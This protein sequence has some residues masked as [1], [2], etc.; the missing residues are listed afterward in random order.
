MRAARCVDA[1]E[2][3]SRYFFFETRPTALRWACSTSSS[4]CRSTYSRRPTLER[5][6]IGHVD[7]IDHVDRVPWADLCAVLAA[8]ASIEIDVAKSLE[9]CVL[10]AGDLVDAVDRADLKAGLA[11]GATIG[12]NHRQN[13]GDDFSRLSGQGRCCHLSNPQG[14]RRHTHSR[15][16]DRKLKNRSSNSPRLQFFRCDRQKRPNLG[17]ERPT[18]GSWNDYRSSCCH[19]QAANKMG[20]K[21][22]SI[23]ALADPPQSQRCPSENFRNMAKQTADETRRSRAKGRFDSTGMI[24]RT[25]S[26]ARTSEKITSRVSGNPT[27]SSVKFLRLRE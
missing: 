11:P 26:E 17:E 9:R 2:Q 20:S 24:A 25:L 1:V 14:P 16:Q 4:Q 21:L 7:R 22:G 18:H 13:L 15:S 23:S 5:D 8:D 6:V 27:V 12:V 3:A 10:L 19:G